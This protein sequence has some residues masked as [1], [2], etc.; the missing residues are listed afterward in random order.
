M[1][2]KK[3]EREGEVKEEKDPMCKKRYYFLKCNSSLII[4][5]DVYTQFLQKCYIYIVN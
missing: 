1:R 5:H 2:E 4:M 3:K